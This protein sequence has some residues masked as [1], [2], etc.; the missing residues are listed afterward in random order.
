MAAPGLRQLVQLS[1]R[2]E[3]PHF[4]SCSPY[5]LSIYHSHCMDGPFI[6]NHDYLHLEHGDFP[7]RCV[8]ELE[9]TIFPH[10]QMGIDGVYR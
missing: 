7:V 1:G 8:E 2:A 10:E 6:D 5:P 4:G 9:A 3:G